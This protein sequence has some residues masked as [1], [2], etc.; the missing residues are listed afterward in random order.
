MTRIFNS[1][2]DG[3]I[4]KAIADRQQD[5]GDAEEFDAAAVAERVTPRAAKK[6]TIYGGDDAA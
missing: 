2:E 6:L 5:A 4:A 3:G 1:F